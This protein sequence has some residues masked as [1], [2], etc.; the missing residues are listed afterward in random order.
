MGTRTEAIDALQQVAGQGEAPHLRHPRSRTPSHFDR[1]MFV[2]DGVA[3]APVTAKVAALVKNLPTNP[4]TTQPTAAGQQ[5]IS[6]PASASARQVERQALP[7]VGDE[8]RPSR[9]V[10][11]S[12]SETVR[13]TGG[14][15]MQRSF[16][17]M[18]NVK[19]LA[20]LLFRSPLTSTRGR[21]AARRATVRVPPIARHRRVAPTR[22]M[23]QLQLTLTKTSAQYF[24]ALLKGAAEPPGGSKRVL[25]TLTDLDINDINRITAIVKALPDDDSRTNSPD[26]R[27]T[28][29]VAI[30]RS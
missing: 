21:H 27:S 28:C 1:F 2:Y 22:E 3:P 29:G 6:D 13:A 10:A 17:D 25:F 26:V 11:G 9:V 19:T 14:Y 8:P 16:A 24:T 4:T 7:D 30:D 15:L 5:Y 12:A 23:W 18:F 20:G